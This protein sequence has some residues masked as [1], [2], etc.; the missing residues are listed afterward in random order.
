M[1][2]CHGFQSLSLYTAVHFT[3]FIIKY[4]IVSAEFLDGMLR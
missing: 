1:L 2:S 3:G 4:D